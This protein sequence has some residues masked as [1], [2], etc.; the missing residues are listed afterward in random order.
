MSK[1]GHRKI[2]ENYNCLSGR[3]SVTDHRQT[4]RQTDW[5]QQIANVNVSSRSLKSR[6]GTA[7]P[8]FGRCPLWPNGWMHQDATSYGGRPRPWRHCVTWGH[9]SPKKGTQQHLTFRP[10]YCGQ[11][12]GWIKMPLRRRYSLGPLHFVLNGTQLPPPKKKLAQQPHTFPR[13]L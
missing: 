3:T 2:A 8:H 6:S 7:A 4:D 12:A 10:M 11:T 9:S 13:L 5:R 1:D